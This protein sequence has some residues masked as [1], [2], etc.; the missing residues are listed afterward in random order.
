MFG[1]NVPVK[2]DNSFPNCSDCI[3]PMTKFSAVSNSEAVRP[4]SVRF[5]LDLEFSINLKIQPIT[6]SNLPLLLNLLMSTMS[7]NLPPCCSLVERA[8]V[9]VG[10]F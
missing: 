8:N 3:L 7:D 5:L 4:I 10:G 2:N 6:L 9:S 1:T